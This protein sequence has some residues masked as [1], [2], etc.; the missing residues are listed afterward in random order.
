[1]LAMEPPKL[2]T[3][4]VH[5]FVCS[6]NKTTN[7]SMVRVI[8]RLAERLVEE[9]H[10]LKK[11]HAKEGF[12]ICSKEFQDDRRSNE[13]AETSSN[14]GNIQTGRMNSHP[15]FPCWEKSGKKNNKIKERIEKSM[16]DYLPRSGSPSPSIENMDVN[17]DQEE[18]MEEAEA[19]LSIER[20]E[21]DLVIKKINLNEQSSDEEGEG[22]LEEFLDKPL[23]EG[24]RKIKDSF[25][26]G[27]SDDNDNQEESEDDELS[28]KNGNTAEFN[29][30]NNRFIPLGK[31]SGKRDTLQN[32]LGK[33]LYLARNE[34]NYSIK[35][36]LH[37]SWAAKKEANKS[38]IQ[39]FKGKRIVF[40]EKEEPE[41]QS[42]KGLHPSWAAK[43]EANKSSIQ[44]FKGTKIVMAE[45]RLF[46][47]NVCPQATEDDFNN[48]L[49]SYGTVKK[50]E[51]KNK[52]DIDGNVL[53]TFAFVDMI[54]PKSQLEECVEKCS[55]SSWWEGYKI[56]IQIAK[57]SFMSRLAKERE[58]STKNKSESV[59]E[60]RS[61]KGA[62]YK[63]IV[64][65]EEE[66]DFGDK[67]PDGK[68]I[69]G[70]IQFD[71]SHSKQNTS[72]RK[73]VRKYYSSSSDEDDETDGVRTK[74]KTPK[75]SGGAF[76]RKL[77]SFDSDFW[78]EEEEKKKT[79][80]FNSYQDESSFRSKG[81][82]NSKNNLKNDQ[83]SNLEPLG[84]GVRAEKSLGKARQK[85]KV[86]EQNVNY[87]LEPLGTS[88]PNKSHFGNDDDVKRVTSLKQQD[89]AQI[90][91]PD[92]M[93]VMKNLIQKL[94][95]SIRVMMKI[96]KQRRIVSEKDLNSRDHLGIVFLVSKAILEG[97]IALRWIIV[98]LILQELKFDP[99][100]DKATLSVEKS[101]G[102]VELEEDGDEVENNSEALDIE[103][104]ETR[105]YEVSEDL[106]SAF[107]S[108]RETNTNSSSF[109]LLKAFGNDLEHVAEKQT[110]NYVALKIKSDKK[111][112]L[113]TANPFKYDSSDNEDEENSESKIGSTKE[114]IQYG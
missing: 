111:K 51:I 59:V 22:S 10:L 56:K 8:N 18:E 62:P 45:G 54:A 65:E 23:S 91:S 98:L 37:P 12:F 43:K 77:E 82:S 55:N 60:A 52:K 71:E 35:Q 101:D 100:N 33:K 88:G 40:G 21:G 72:F 17:S 30:F 73:P 50:V 36:D 31:L 41:K 7:K 76:M 99:L 63:R 89:K 80:L 95:Y 103:K 49:S 109:S 29:Q 75:Y 105:F 87:N 14:S 42:H 69:G 97:M 84:G 96:M 104:M 74:P 4:V 79:R 6:L 11:T 81:F 3:A 102:D 83:N 34:G 1:M 92:T 48:N 16:K 90:K 68:S 61:H 38:S 108:N 39:D 47:G 114:T 27:G 57:E 93:K 58:S 28:S 9:L 25:F 66:T 106:K 113:F 44:E 70:V 94:S 85:D 86:F 20:K 53:S 107:I 110:D 24:S 5:D 19:E 64:I 15:F 112:D 67:V 46:I 13:R 26:L 78:K 32:L 2:N